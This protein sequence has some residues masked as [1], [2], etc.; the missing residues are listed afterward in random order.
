MEFDRFFPQGWLQNVD[1]IAGCRGNDNIISDRGNQKLIFHPFLRHYLTE[2]ALW[3]TEFMIIN[4]KTTW[5]LPI[6]RDIP[7]M[8][9]SER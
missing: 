9:T 4:K 8:T 1:E 5:M 6:V 2:L 7:Y 3:S